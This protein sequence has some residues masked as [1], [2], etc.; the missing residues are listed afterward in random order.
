WGTARIGAAMHRWGERTLGFRT[1]VD[2]ELPRADTP[3]QRPLIVFVRH[4]SLADGFLPAALLGVDRGWAPRVVLKRELV[5][6]PWI[7]LASG[8]YP[9]RFVD[10]RAGRGPAEA[11]HLAS[12]AT[13]LVPG[14]A[15]FVWP[16]GTLFSPAKRERAIA[17][18]RAAGDEAGAAYAA[19]LG[20]TLS[21]LRRGPLALLAANQGADLLVL[22]HRG[23]DDGSDRRQLVGGGFVGRTMTV[24]GWSVPWDELHAAGDGGAARL[25]AVWREV[26]AFAGSAYLAQPSS[27]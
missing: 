23:M 14:E 17:A 22:G 13:D 1:V 24:R 25:A 18:L 16:E 15:V 26:D 7:D 19:S 10:R 12:L 6:N 20:H 11:A 3:G 21:P 27:T 4:A 5:W 2:G 9:N 8:A